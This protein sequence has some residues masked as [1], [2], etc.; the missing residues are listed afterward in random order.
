MCDR[1][2]RRTLV[3]PTVLRARP[4]VSRRAALGM[5]TSTM[6]VA[7][8]AALLPHNPVFAQAPEPRPKPSRFRDAFGSYRFTVG[9]FDCLCVSDGALTFPAQ[10]YAANAPAVEIASVLEARFLPPEQVTNQTTAMLIDTGESL[11]LIDTG[12]AEPQKPLVQVPDAAAALRQLGRLREHLAAAGVALGDVDVVVLTHGHPDHVGGLLDEAGDL[13]FPNARYVMD[14]RDWA[15]WT[16]PLEEL[17]EAEAASAAVP[18]RVLPPIAD[19]VEFAAPGEAIVPGIEVVEAAGHTPGHM[20][21]VISSGDATL[22]H[23]CDAAAHYVLSLARPDWSFVGDVEPERALAARRRLF[24]RAAADR[25]LVFASH[26]PFPSLGH[27]TAQADRWEWEPIYYR[28][29]Y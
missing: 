6:A 21:L 23:T 24:D 11:V 5:G 13:V 15:Y 10:W 20:A 17:T 26:F 12:M 22:L 9:S 29:A 18:L 2:P 19:R 8:M 7:A 16:R 27:V 1:A 14:E 3:S 28:W 25:T 4:M